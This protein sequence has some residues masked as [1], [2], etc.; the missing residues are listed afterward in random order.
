MI[1]EIFNEHVMGLYV[2]DVIIRDMISDAD[3]VVKLQPI[4]RHSSELIAIVILN[5][6]AKDWHRSTITT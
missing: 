5:C 6:A 1:F 4:G 3:I 2:Y